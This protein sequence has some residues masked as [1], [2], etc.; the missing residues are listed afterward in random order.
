MFNQQVLS[1][2]VISEPVRTALATLRQHID[3]TAVNQA[4]NW[5]EQSEQHHILTCEHAHWPTGFSLLSSPPLV[6]FAVG[7]V[8]RL[9]DT[10][11]AI[12]GSRRATFSGLQHA[13]MF[14]TQLAQA[15]ITI[16]SGLATGIDSAAHKGAMSF[17]GRTI[18]SAKP[19]DRVCCSWNIGCRSVVEKWHLDNGEFGRKYG[20]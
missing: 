10:Q 2:D 17:E 6:L 9:S 14:A 18:A 8:S 5:L 20:A 3:I 12:V 13:E 16:T 11:I 1:S 7:N 19:P 15:G 4:I